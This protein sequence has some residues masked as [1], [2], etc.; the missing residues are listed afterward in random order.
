VQPQGLR[1]HS[2]LNWAPAAV[3]PMGISEEFVTQ[4]FEA[5]GH[6][7]S[8]Q[9]LCHNPR[10]RRLKCRKLEGAFR[11]RALILIQESH[12]SQAEPETMLARPPFSASYHGYFQGRESGGA[13]GLAVLAPGLARAEREQLRNDA[14]AGRSPSFLKPVATPRSIVDSRPQLITITNHNSDHEIRILNAHNYDLNDAQ[15]VRPRDEWTTH[16]LWSNS[17]PLRF[18]FIAMGDFSFSDGPSQSHLAPQPASAARPSR[19]ACRRTRASGAS[20]QRHRDQLWHPD[21]PLQTS[22][23][24]HHDRQGLRCHSRP[25][26][27]PRLHC[28]LNIAQDSSALSGTRF[29]DHAIMKLAIETRQPPAKDQRPLPDFVFRSKQH[30]SL[31]TKMPSEAELDNM[32]DIRRYDVTMQIMFLAA[33][34]VRNELQRLPLGTGDVNALESRRLKPRA[35]ARAIWRADLPTARL[36]A[37]TAELGQ[38]SLGASGFPPQLRDSAE[39]Q[40]AAIRD[41]HTRHEREQH[42]A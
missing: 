41:N 40:N 5:T 22:P 7:A 12:G 26:F 6:N 9:I 21:P 39:F 10:R 19:A 17:D 18:A 27:I 16:T 14:A 8:L 28:E 37:A 23:D 32:K 38:R 30:K 29:S 1:E 25:L 35:I 36:L 42:L 20:L 11:S 13:G 3:A 15:K 2:K 34:L 31:V 33:D 4:R 24:G